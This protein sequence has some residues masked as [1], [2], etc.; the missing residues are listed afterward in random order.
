MSSSLLARFV[1][2]YYAHL[3]PGDASEHSAADLEG[4]ARSHLRFAEDRPAGEALVRVSNPAFDQDGYDS[5]HTIVE[6]VTDDMPFLVDSVAMALTRHGLGIHLVVHPIVPVRRDDKGHLIDLAEEDDTA[7]REAFMHFEVDRE[8]DATLLADLRAD[9]LDVLR[10]VRNAVDDWQAMRTKALDV[11]RS[12][13]DAEAGALLD[14]MADDHFTFLGYCDTTAHGSGLGIL[15]GADVH[16]GE[17]QVGLTV[18]KSDARATVHR[19]VHMEQVCVGPHQLL[20]LWASAAYNTSPLDIPLL[21]RKANV[22]LDRAEFP[23]SSHSGKDLASILET[24]P[25]DELFQ[26]GEDEL[27]VTAMGILSLQER[28]RVRLFVRRDDLGRFF[29]SLVYLPRDRF[30]TELARRIE[31]ILI[32][33]LGGA[34]AETTVRM[35][36]SVLARLHVIVSLPVGAPA[37]APDVPAIEARLAAAARSWTDDL[38]QE[39][40]EHNGE[41]RGIDLLRKYGDAFPAAYRED[42]DPRSAVGDVARIESLLAGSVG[43]DLLSAVTRPADAPRDFVRMRLFRVGE[44]MALSDVLPLLEHLGV[45]VVDER[46]YEV[47]PAESPAVWLYDVGLTSPDLAGLDGE[48]ARVE[49]CDAFGRLWRGEAESD[50]FNRLVLR[51]SLSSRKVAVLRA[52]AKY[53]RQIGSTFS[54]SYIEDTLAT[55]AHIAAMLL[56]LFAARFD[57]D[58][59]ADRTE[60]E[61]ELVT[62]IVDALR[63]VASLDEDRILSSLLN[64]ILATLRTSWY[65]RDAAGNPKPYMSFKLDPA[66]VPDLPLPR[67]LFEV[68]VY[69]PRTEGVHLRGG[70]IA[71]GGIRWSDRRED[72]RTEILGLMKA[73]M[74]KNAVIVPV[75]AKGGFVVKR[76]PAGPDRDALQAEVE[77]C[78]QILIRG[79]FDVTDNLV[80][81]DVVTPPRVVRY[82]DDD[83]YLVVAADKGTATFSDLANSIAAEYGFWLGDAFASG[84]SAGYD[85]KEMGITARGAWESVRRH[86]LGLGIN[87]DKDAFTV[88]GIGDMSGD[89]FGNAML[90]S[91]MIELVGAF[92]HRHVFIDPKPDPAASFAERRR[93][94]ELPR[95]SWDDYNRSLVSA[96]GG[97]WP[98]TAKSIPLSPEARELLCTDAEALTPAEVITALLEAPVD[99]LFNGGIGTYVKA[100]TESHGEV[101]DRANDALRVNGRR[102]PLQGS[103]RGRQ[104]RAHTARARRVRARGRPGEHRRHRQLRRRRHL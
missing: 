67:P 9:L 70:R 99:L 10:D 79:L 23:R 50:G 28:K 80:G 94:F 54:Q 4:A 20:G 59:T 32:D 13:S 83:P 100:S 33:A 45:R 12:V 57:P 92:D 39:L 41:E 89:V 68:W 81:T 90:L 88:V 29:S 96:G 19:P 35:S 44:P 61:E 53:L 60:A 47:H 14:W 48:R 1:T 5:T 62:S 55:N 11:A 37:T 73:Q 85:H 51:A 8:T 71:R 91:P 78:Y 40:A 38:A 74:V 56:D 77:A 63:D 76:P 17:P 18:R 30:T 102:P 58:R 84:G 72:F 21:R 26:I 93:L 16:A 69:S 103:R 101:G 31:T 27:Y 52:Y 104:P 7:V 97:V 24:Y 75:G 86:F 98:R 43:T 64:L 66:R 2:L 87:P 15:R 22:V 34:A 3:D 65:Q 42:V 46:P 6:I 95:S 49:F 82:D 36:E 25:R